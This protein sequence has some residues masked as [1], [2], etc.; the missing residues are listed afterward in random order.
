MRLNAWSSDDWVITEELEEAT[1]DVAKGA[2]DAGEGVAEV[3]GERD[4]VLGASVEAW[5]ELGCGIIFNG[6]VGSNEPYWEI[7][8]VT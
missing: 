4:V 7:G 3:A 2:G 8:I 1:V 5:P 6:E